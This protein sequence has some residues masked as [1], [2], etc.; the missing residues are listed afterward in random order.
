MKLAKLLLGDIVRSVH[1]KVLRLLVHRESD[2]LADVGRVSKEHHHAVDAGRD[3]AVG[4]RAE[5]ERIVEAAELLLNNLLRV[6][7]NF[8]RLLHNV[9]TMVADSAGREF[10]AV[11]DDIV[12]I[13]LNLKRWLVV[14][15]VN[16][17]LRH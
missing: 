9:D 4:R 3:A 12:L 15:R 11:A 6:S 1:H 10:N 7:C 8:K 16:A 14:E 13:R 17:A 5:L 2:D